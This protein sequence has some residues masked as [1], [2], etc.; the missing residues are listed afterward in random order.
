MDE[1]A[2][3]SSPEE[4][5]ST[6]PKLNAKFRKKTEHGL[7]SGS[8]G[9][10]GNCLVTKKD[11]GYVFVNTWGWCRKSEKISNGGEPEGSTTPENVKTLEVT[12]MTEL[13]A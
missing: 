3:A 7:P 11:P 10:R 2:R 6:D 9:R 1:Q 13:H 8:R 12:P 5:S 4:P